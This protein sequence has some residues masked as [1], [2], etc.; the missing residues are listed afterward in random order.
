MG[1]GKDMDAVVF[2]FRA[3][4]D[5]ATRFVGATA[6]NP[7]VGAAALDSRGRLLGVRAH[8]RAG[9]THAEAALLEALRARGELGALDTL[10][11][12]L[13][14]CNH[15]G[16]TPPCTLAILEAARES[17]L[18]RIIYG[19]RDPNP[20]VAGGGVEF[21]ASYGPGH[22]RGLEI[23]ALASF[24]G[25]E[26]LERDCRRLLAP[27]ACWT[28][29]GRP[30]VTVKT[31]RL[32]DGCRIPPPG[33]KTF[34]SAESLVLAHRLRKRSDAI[35]T[36]SGTI[37]ADQPEFTVRHVPDHPGKHR[38]LVIL[39]RRQRVPA[40]YLKQAEDRGLIPIIASDPLGALEEL[41][42]LG[43]LE[44]L[45]EAGP[46]LSDALLSDNRCL[47][48]EHVVITL[49]NPDSVEI[50]TRQAF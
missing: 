47:W 12:T 46:S 22:G 33:Q 37:L 21:L 42:K 15:Q 43:A 1:S 14:P 17:G 2:G 36:G 11:V 38:W 18:R 41:G 3:A 32:E 30:W 40:S 48:N 6:P 28:T 25:T 44:V 49:G 31:A 50:R 34:T 23:R 5:E 13:E 45:V 10:L 8:E 39:D 20:K 27:F 9:A 29:T 7:P 16:R 19:Q 35:L 26:L 4:L 24:G